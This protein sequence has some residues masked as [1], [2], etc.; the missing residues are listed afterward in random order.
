MVNA[1]SAVSADSLRSVAAVGNDPRFSRPRELPS[2]RAEADLRQRIAAGEWASPAALPSIA[3]LAGHDSTSR[4]TLAKAL[5][6]LADDGP[7][8]IVPSGGTFRT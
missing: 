8:E 5:R 7:P 2:R 3:A 6:L 4:A 1:V